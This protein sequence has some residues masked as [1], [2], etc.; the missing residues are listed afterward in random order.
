MARN[1]KGQFAGK[2]L[3]SDTLGLMTQHGKTHLAGML[4]KFA[5]DIEGLNQVR[6][7]EIVQE[8]CRAEGIPFAGQ[9]YLE[10]ISAQYPQI[11]HIVAIAKVQQDLRQAYR[12]IL[13][14]QDV[15]KTLEG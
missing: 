7:L 9:N 13:Q 15:L 2:T 3:E 10:S 4:A 14:T 11:A 12:K 6:P 1:N 5:E 8:F